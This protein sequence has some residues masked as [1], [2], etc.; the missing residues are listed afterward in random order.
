MAERLPEIMELQPLGVAHI[1]GPGGLGTF[2]VEGTTFRGRMW[3]ALASNQV[4]PHAAAAPGGAE[5]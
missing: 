1:A 3:D 2:V 4:S 5:D